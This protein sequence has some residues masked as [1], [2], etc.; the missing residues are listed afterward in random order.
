MKIIL[1]LMKLGQAAL[2]PSERNSPKRLQVDKTAVGQFIMYCAYQAGMRMAG[3][4]MPLLICRAGWVTRVEARTP[5][6]AIF[7]SAR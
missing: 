2:F 4:S 5:A 7:P 6:G 3:S 1:G